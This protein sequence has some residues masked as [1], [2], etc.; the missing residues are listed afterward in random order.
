MYEVARSNDRLA[1]F[2]M[3]IGPEIFAFESEDGDYTGSGQSMT[4]SQ[5]LFYEKHGFYIIA[6]DYILRPEVL[7]S[8]FY[9]WRVTGDTKYFDRAANALQQFEKY[10]KVPGDG[11]TGYGGRMDVTVADSD[12]VDDTESF[13]FAEVLKYL[14]V[15]FY[16]HL[17]Q[18]IPSPIPP[19]LPGT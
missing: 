15:F 5:T 9:A 3:G 8:N 12:R 11:I 4:L 1:F 14:Y 2:R 7:E 19:N 6:A 16:F 13:W 10:L 17:G 18:S